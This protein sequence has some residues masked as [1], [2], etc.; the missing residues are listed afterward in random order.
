MSGE[1]SFHISLADYKFNL[2]DTGILFRDLP[3]N[4]TSGLYFHVL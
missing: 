2:H 4:Y 3:S 1:N